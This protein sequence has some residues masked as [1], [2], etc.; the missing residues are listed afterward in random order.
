MGASLVQLARGFESRRLHRAR[1]GAEREGTGMDSREQSILDDRAQRGFAFLAQKRPGF[2]GSALDL[3]A[4]DMNQPAD[5]VLG[6]TYGDYYDACDEL[7][8]SHCGAEAAHYGFV[9]PTVVAHDYEAEVYGALTDS[10]RR[11]VLAHRNEIATELTGMGWLLTRDGRAMVS[12]STGREW[13]IG[14]EFSL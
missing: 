9:F 4:L 7:G 10:W 12:P 2:T 14:N 6:Q 13:Q 8:L 5:C 3:D 11:I 1:P